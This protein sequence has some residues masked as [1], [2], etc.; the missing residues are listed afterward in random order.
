LNTFVDGARDFCNRRGMAYL[1]A[2]TNLPV[3]QL[4]GGY[5]RK[6]GLVR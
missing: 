2:Q 5:L 3:D 6:R 4:V 1:L